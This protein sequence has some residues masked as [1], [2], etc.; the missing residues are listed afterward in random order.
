M[1][2]ATMKYILEMVAVLLMVA[3]VVPIAMT[4]LFNGTDSW[5]NTPTY[6]ITLLTDVVAVFFALGVMIKMMPSDVKSKIGLWC[7]PYVPTEYT[8]SQPNS[9]HIQLEISAISHFEGIG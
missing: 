2:S 3:F 8:Y 5:G 7:V 6:V 9:K 4:Y 1:A